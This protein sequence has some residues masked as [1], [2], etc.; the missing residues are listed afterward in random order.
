MAKLWKKGKICVNCWW[1]KPRLW[2]VYL[3]YNFECQWLIELSNN[4]LCHNKLSDNKPSENNRGNCNFWLMLKIKQL[5]S[6]YTQF[7]SLPCM[8]CVRT[9]F[10]LHWRF[11]FQEKILL[12]RLE[13][14]E[15]IFCKDL[16]L[17]VVPISL[18]PCSS[19]KEDCVTSP[20]SLGG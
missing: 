18:R 20:K 2:L 11:A 3:N 15:F 7:V 13:E 10:K 6:V 12:Q 9:V 16:H 19:R 8:C 14:N 17:T 5:C 4:K 1:L